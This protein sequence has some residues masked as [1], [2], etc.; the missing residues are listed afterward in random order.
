MQ[1]VIWGHFLD[2]LKVQTGGMARILPRIWYLPQATRFGL[3]RCSEQKWDLL[4]AP[5]PTYEITQDFTSFSQRKAQSG[6]TVPM[7]IQK[8]AGLLRFGRGHVSGLCAVCKVKKPHSL[9]FLLTYL[10][11]Y[12]V[13]SIHSFILI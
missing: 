11:I 9:N 3:W 1:S 8:G 4:L 5:T 10:Y 12:I 6:N 13:L 7:P 2:S